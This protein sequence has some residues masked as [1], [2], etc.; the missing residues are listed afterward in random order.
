M[1]KNLGYIVYRT[2][3]EYYGG[4]GDIEEDAYGEYNSLPS[5]PNDYID[6]TELIYSS[7]SIIFPLHSAINRYEE[8]NAPRH[9]EEIRDSTKT[10][11]T[12]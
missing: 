2:V 10:S 5:I 3:I 6:N 1:Y 9:R 12:L 4:P 11:C 7:C 8:S